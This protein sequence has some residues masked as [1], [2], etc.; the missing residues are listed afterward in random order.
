[1]LLILR[2]GGIFGLLETQQKADQVG[3]LGRRERLDQ[4]RR[5][6]GDIPHAADVD[7]RLGD[8]GDLGLGVGQFERGVGLGRGR[9]RSRPCRRGWRRSRADSPSRSAWMAPGA[10]GSPRPGRISRPG[11]SGRGRSRRIPARPRRGIAH[12]RPPCVSKKIAAP[13]LGSPSCASAKIAKVFE[14]CRRRAAHSGPR[15]DPRDLEPETP[16][17]DPLPANDQDPV[18]SLCQLEPHQIGVGSVCPCRRNCCIDRRAVSLTVTISVPLEPIKHE[19]RARAVGVDL[20]IGEGA[21]IGRA[22]A[23][24]AESAPIAGPVLEV[25]QVHAAGRRVG[26][27]GHPRDRSAESARMRTGRS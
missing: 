15:G 18:L 17:P 7:V 13:F 24:V 5:H 11:R 14:R 2:C 27:P 10:T 23:V 1:M 9:R 16:R 4:L 3:E 20:G 19:G 12:S 8:S 6:D 26:L 22:V 21:E 25:A